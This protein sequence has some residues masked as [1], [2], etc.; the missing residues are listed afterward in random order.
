[1]YINHD[2]KLIYIPIDKCASSFLKEHLP[3]EEN[4]VKNTS[5]RKLFSGYNY[6]AIIRNPKERWISGLNQYIYNEM[7]ICYRKFYYE[8]IKFFETNQE[9]EDYCN[10]FS[11]YL[12]DREKLIFEYVRKKLLNNKFI[13]DGHTNPQSRIVDIFIKYYSC[14]IIGFVLVK[15]DNNL[16]K[17]IQ[18]IL[19]NDENNLSHFNDSTSG[20]SASESVYKSEILPKCQQYYLEFCENNEEFYNQYLDDY[21]LFN[22]AI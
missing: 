15:L 12:E 5:T 13:F 1:M 6:F 2:K 11:N 10:K 16:T 14:N 7:K 18:S 20:H 19:G 8:N 22:R 4:F 3:R 17:K 9:H 21:K